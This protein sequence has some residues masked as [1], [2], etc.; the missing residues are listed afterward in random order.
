MNNLLHFDPWSQISHP[1][2]VACVISV[3]AFEI[4]TVQPLARCIERAIDSPAK[5]SLIA[6][7]FGA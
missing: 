6:P 3:P 1:Q 7:E 5:L 4:A 2:E